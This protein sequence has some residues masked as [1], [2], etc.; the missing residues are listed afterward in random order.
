MMLLGSQRVMIMAWIPHLHAIIFEDIGRL[1]VGA[2]GIESEKKIAPG[3]LPART[4]TE[5]G[6]I[7]PS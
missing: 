3:R 2:L 7:L 1:S 5:Q 4:K 6:Q